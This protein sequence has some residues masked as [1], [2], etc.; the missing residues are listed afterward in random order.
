VTATGSH[1]Y[2][3]AYGSCMCPQ[4]LQRSLGEP[5]VPLAA[6]AVLAGY[7]LGYTRFSLARQGGVLD[8]LP[9]PA[10]RVLGVLYALPWHVSDRLDAR[11]AVPSGGYRRATVTVTADERSFAATRTYTVVEKRAVEC[12]PDDRYL[13]IVWRG[14]L[15]SGLPPAYCQQLRARARHLQTRAARSPAAQ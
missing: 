4:D 15:A 13:D 12:P 7:R 8:I 1:F 9:E 5:V 3:F 11:E 14:A 2:Y 10:S 6:P